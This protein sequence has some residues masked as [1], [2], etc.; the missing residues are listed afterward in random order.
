MHGSPPDL[1]KVHGR[2]SLISMPTH[3]SHASKESITWQRYHTAGGCRGAHPQRRRRRLLHPRLQRQRRPAQGHRALPRRRRRRGSASSR[4]G[5]PGAA[6]RRRRRRAADVPG[7][8]PRA[9]A[10]DSDQ[11]AGGGG[12]L[13]AEPL[14]AAA[15]R[16]PPRHR[17]QGPALHAPC[18]CASCCSRPHPCC[19][20]C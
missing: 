9:A 13:P 3:P 5:L 12:G 8:R 1:L 11:P 15:G 14:Q 18:A 17:A 7:R 2:M 19:C 6:R 10:S 16:G 4:A 20:R